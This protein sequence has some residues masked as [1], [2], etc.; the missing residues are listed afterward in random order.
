MKQR[1]DVVY[2]VLCFIGTNQC[3]SCLLQARRCVCGDLCLPDPL[4][5]SH[6][7]YMSS[8]TYLRVQQKLSL[9]LIHQPEWR[10]YVRSPNLFGSDSCIQF[11]WPDEIMCFKIRSDRFHPVNDVPSNPA[12]GGGVSDLGFS[13]QQVVCSGKLERKK[14]KTKGFEEQIKTRWKQADLSFPEMLPNQSLCCWNRLWG[15]LSDKWGTGT[16][17]CWPVS[18]PSS[19]KSKSIARGRMHW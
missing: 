6:S 11:Q 15:M 14:H 19:G 5:V 9:K 13:L 4:Q 2:M 7:K 16:A 1:V 3:T 10:K 8:P 17:G 12:S 18:Q